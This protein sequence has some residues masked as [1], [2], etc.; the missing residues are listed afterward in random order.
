VPNAEI[1]TIARRGFRALSAATVLGALPNGVLSMMM[2]ASAASAAIGSRPCAVLPSMT[3]LRFDVLR[4]RKRT[5][6]S[7]PD[8]AR[9]EALQ[10]RSGSPCGGSTLRTSA[11]ASAS[12]LVQYGPAISLERSSTRTPA[13]GGDI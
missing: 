8:S 3:A 9:P 5:P 13:S 4:K 2:S 1:E 6:S 10:C 11:P 12:S 7:A